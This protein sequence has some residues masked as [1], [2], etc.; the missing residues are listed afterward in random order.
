RRGGGG[1][2]ARRGG[3]SRRKPLPSEGGGNAERGPPEAPDATLGSLQLAR[4]EVEPSGDLT[5]DDRDQPR[6]L[7]VA[8]QKGVREQCGALLCRQLEERLRLSVPEL[9]VRDDLDRRSGP[10]HRRAPSSSAAADAIVDVDRVDGA[11]ADRQ[12]QV[13]V[14]RRAEGR[15]DETGADRLL[16]ARRVRR[17]AAEEAVDADDVGRRNSRAPGAL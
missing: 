2:R 1:K 13:R 7:V 15:V 4:D 10:A 11:R 14:L 5:V 12:R 9:R 8:A 17:V 16:D 3:Q 6:R